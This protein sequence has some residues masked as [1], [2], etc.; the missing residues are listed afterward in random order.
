MPLFY[1]TAVPQRHKMRGKSDNMKNLENISK[2][3]NP[4][5]RIFFK[6]SRCDIKARMYFYQIII[7]KNTFSLLCRFLPKSEVKATCRFLPK[8]G[9]KAIPL[10][11]RTATFQIRDTAATL[12]STQVTVAKVYTHGNKSSSF[13]QNSVELLYLNNSGKLTSTLTEFFQEKNPIA[14]MLS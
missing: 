6:M 14:S 12:V 8:S 2:I 5:S 4:K 3:Q 9:I 11:C 7:S 1:T 13:W 10:L